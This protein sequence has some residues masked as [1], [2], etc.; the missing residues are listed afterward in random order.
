MSTSTKSKPRSAYSKRVVH[1]NAR[2]SNG[3]PNPNAKYMTWM[4]ADNCGG[5]VN[6]AAVG[7]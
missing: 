1:R 4:T 5:K 3:A 6:T 2:R 7:C